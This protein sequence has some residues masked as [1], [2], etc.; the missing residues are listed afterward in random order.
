MDGRGG[1]RC[2]GLVAALAV[3][4]ALVLGPGG[5]A[6]ASPLRGPGTPL[7]G[8][9][10]GSYATFGGDPWVWCVDAGR[11]LPE[12]GHAWTS[13]PV[14]APAVA[15]ALS[16]H[17]TQARPDTHAALSYLVHTS[18]DLPHDAVAAVPPQPPVAA[19]MD[20]PRRVA[21]L[22]DE[23][24]RLSGPYSVPVEL[25]VDPDRRGAA[26]TVSVESAAGHLLPGRPLV[27]QL[28]G[29]AAWDY[30][31]TRRAAASGTEPA[32][33][34]LVATGDGVVTVTVEAAVPPV[35]VQLF[36]PGRAGVQR[37]VGAAPPAGAS[38]SATAGLRATFA[39]RVT[40]RT[41]DAVAA[42]GAVLTDLLD[43]GTRDRTT[44][45]PGVTVE[46]VST[47]WGPFTEAP[48]EAGSAPEGAPVVGQVTTPVEG[49]G[50]VQTGGLELPGPG[51]YVWT[52]QVVADDHQTGW[53]GRFGVAEETTLARWQPSVETQ[54][55]EA[56]TFV[57]AELRDHLTVTGVRPGAS[58]VVRS[59]LWGP[60]PQRPSEAPTVPE[61][62][63]AVGTVETTV[64]GDDSWTT[65]ALAVRAPGWYVWTETIAEDSHHAGWTSTF[66]RVVETTHV[67]APVE[68]PTTV[69]SPAVV[70]EVEVQA[71]RHVVQLPRTGADPLA[72]SWAGA[73]LVVVGGGLLASSRRH[74]RAARHR[75]DPG[76]TPQAT[77]SSGW[78]PQRPTPGRQPTDGP[79]ARW[80]SESPWPRAVSR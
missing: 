79:R 36:D 71:S 59:T 2:A 53:S 5:A 65:D 74:Q 6:G 34:R 48:A 20:L 19:G 33:W 14:R 21:A 16:Q 75:A 47:L 70:P 44:W 28:S 4:A 1:T 22:A 58:V 61:G 12:P 17:G 54:T 35:D 13:S 8:T 49:T 55:S 68:A 78:V 26:V 7:P 56:V 18:P 27:A 41:S 52:E 50:T 45:P 57:G 46:V 66:G 67:P 73:G 29:P 24:A 42:P 10:L 43:V 62:S 23:A 30:G 32:T 51:Y 64:D 60:F 3:V 76:A 77:P 9:W 25:A 15:Y 39:P 63:P 31:S 40:T 38:G 69:Q 37:V 80:R 72:A 11:A